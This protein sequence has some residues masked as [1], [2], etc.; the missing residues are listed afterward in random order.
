MILVLKFNQKN[1]QFEAD[2]APGVIVNRVRTFSQT[3]EVHIDCEVALSEKEIHAIERAAVKKYKA[4][5]AEELEDGMTVKERNKLA[6][7]YV[8]DHKN[9]AK[10]GK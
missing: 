2:A 6:D 5:H 8:E 10:R 3:G 7:D 4:E 9:R 1:K